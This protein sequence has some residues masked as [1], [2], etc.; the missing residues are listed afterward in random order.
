MCEACGGKQIT[1]RMDSGNNS[2]GGEQDQLKVA[3]SR[4]FQYCTDRLGRFRRLIEFLLRISRNWCFGQAS[5]FLAAMGW[6]E[7]AVVQYPTAQSALSQGWGGTCTGTL[8]AHSLKP[9][10]I[11]ANFYPKE[12]G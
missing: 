9:L 12:Q 5:K 2:R 11:A 1:K 6:L 4:D 7:W 8:L 10:T 3:T